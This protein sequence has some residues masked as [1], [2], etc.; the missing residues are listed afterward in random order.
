M[1]TRQPSARSAR[2]GVHFTPRRGW[3]NDPHGMT[4]RKDRYHL[5]YQA[6]PSALRWRPWCSWGHATSPTS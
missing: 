6:V 4:F 2:P 5:F 3:I 1:T